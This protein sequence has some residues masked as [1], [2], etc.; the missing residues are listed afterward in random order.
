MISFVA[1]L[2]ALKFAE[3]TRGLGFDGFD[4]VLGTAVICWLG[5]WLSELV[6]SALVTPDSPSSLIQGL[7]MSLGSQVFIT[8]VAIL[9]AG[10]VV[11]GTHL[12]SAFGVIVASVLVVGFTYA[13]TMLMASSRLGAWF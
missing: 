11:K 3:S 2:V 7:S 8:M 1:T 4:D 5:S 13:A 10:A 6:L 9:I 12:R